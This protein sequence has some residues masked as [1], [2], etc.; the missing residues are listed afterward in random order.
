MYIIGANKVTIYTMEADMPIN[1]HGLFMDR[2]TNI[3]RLLSEAYQRAR[4][5][6][7]FFFILFETAHRI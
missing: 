1:L 5:I 6:F 3:R 4:V 7:E 2:S